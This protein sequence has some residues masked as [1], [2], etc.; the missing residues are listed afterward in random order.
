MALA[1]MQRHAEHFLRVAHEHP[2][3]RSADLASVTEVEARIALNL[4]VNMPFVFRTRGQSPNGVRKVERVEVLLSSDYPRRSPRFYLRDDF[5]RDLPHLTPG[6]IRRPP[7]PCLIDGSLDEFFNQHG[8]LELG[9]AFIIEQ[10]CVWLVKAAQGTLMSAQQGWEPPLRG[11]LPD[12]MVFDTSYVR[13]QV[14]KGT[15]SVVLST[16]FLAGRSGVFGA[17]KDVWLE[18]DNEL[19]ALVGNFKAFPFNSRVHESGFT[20]GTTVTGVFWP[21]EK[22]VNA[23]FL[24]DTVENLDELSARAKECGVEASFDTFLQRLATRWRGRNTAFLGPVGVVL[25]VRRPFRMMDRDSS[26]E[27]IP[28]AFEIAAL[29]GR[30]S[31]FEGPAGKAVVP[32]RPL[33]KPTPSLLREVSG[34]PNLAPV[35]IVGCGSVGSK[36][37][38]HL[39]RAG[40]KVTALSDARLLQPHNMARHALVRDGIGQGKAQELVD[41]LKPLGLTPT[42]FDG[43]VVDGIRD[44][45][46]LKVIA[47]PDTKVLLNTTA[48]LLVRSALSSIS[49]DDLSVRI[50]EIALF[51]RGEGA[52]VLWE[53]PARNPSLDDLVVHLYADVTP[54]ERTLLF[55]PE[56]GLSNI[57]IGEGCGTLTMPMTDARLSAM[58]GLAVEQVMRLMSST[59]ENG[60]L[61]VFNRD[62]EGVS[63]TVRRVIVPP[64]VEVGVEKLGW[65]LRL[66]P[67]AKAKIRADIAAY[68]GVETGGVLIGTCCSRTQTITVVDVID[69]PE[70]STRS[71]TLFVLG[72]QG[73]HDKILDRNRESGGAL[74]DVGTWHSHLAEQGPS[75]LDWKTAADLAQVRPPPSVLLIATPSQFLAIADPG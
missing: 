40:A 29:P 43:D 63:T 55:D 32:L 44:P 42:I 19:S 13:S 41:E 72:T 67:S 27:L 24:P 7:V 9:V 51:G 31:L 33:E 60:E 21:D 46:Q 25:C 62:A 74:L 30:R 37:T 66:S 26:I 54:R 58:T 45:D 17:G 56:F 49:Y 11:Q 16:R 59:V 50:G 2:N 1:D 34:A 48:S 28:Y 15:G 70:D 12:W 53:G 20:I 5:P 73:L 52:F 69:A 39:A 10:M 18:P 38:L 14:S 8:M 65:H 68:P 64:F 75:A 6:S 47:P 71:P 57:Q 4:D 61:L 35:A 3:V 36:T 23:N 22:T